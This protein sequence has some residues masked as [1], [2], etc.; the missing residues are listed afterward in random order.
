MREGEISSHC[1]RACGPAAPTR[2]FG[3]AAKVHSN[4]HRVVLVDEMDQR[5]VSAL[6][7]KSWM[8]TVPT[9]MS[10]IPAISPRLSCWPSQTQPIPDTSAMPTP[11]HTA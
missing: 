9:K 3:S 8:T 6:R 2:R 7:E 10:A 5:E 1:C 11:D 4:L